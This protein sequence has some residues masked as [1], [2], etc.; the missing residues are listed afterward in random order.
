MVLYCIICFYKPEMVGHFTIDYIFK[1]IK[2]AL[3][4]LQSL[5]EENQFFYLFISESPRV[6]T[7]SVEDFHIYL[8]IQ[9]KKLYICINECEFNI[10]V[11]HEK[12]PIPPI[13]T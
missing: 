6:I 3:M 5:S 9:K 1:D 12:L 7:G 11:L 2:S 13:S 4:K 10:D 8:D